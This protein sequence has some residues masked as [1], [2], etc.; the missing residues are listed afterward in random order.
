MTSMAARAS[1][2]TLP[3]ERRGR[4]CRSADERAI[5]QQAGTAKAEVINA[6]FALIFIDKVS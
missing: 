5:Y 4:T 6:F 1:T 3:V 2:I